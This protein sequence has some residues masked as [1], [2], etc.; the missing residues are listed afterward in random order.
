MFIYAGTCIYIYIY[1][2]R[3]VIYNEII[4]DTDVYCDSTKDSSF[5]TQIAGPD[6][7]RPCK[8]PSGYVNIAIENCHL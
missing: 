1:I 3:Y 2:G 4:H 7:L 6:F 5:W 8:L